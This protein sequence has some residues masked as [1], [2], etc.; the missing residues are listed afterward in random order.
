VTAEPLGHL[1]AG[2]CRIHL[3]HPIVGVRYLPS[4]AQEYVRAAGDGTVTMRVRAP[5]GSGPQLTVR[6]GGQVRRLTVH[7]GY[8]QWT[9]NVARGQP[10]SWSL[11]RSQ[12]A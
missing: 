5:G 9:V 4:G 11:A 3:E 7:A 8:V 12:A 6:A 10:A 1:H 2:I